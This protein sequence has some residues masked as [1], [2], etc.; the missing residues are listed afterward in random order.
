VKP[1]ASTGGDRVTRTKLTLVA[2]IAAGALACTAQAQELPTGAQAA[3]TGAAPSSAAS[4]AAAPTGAASAKADGVQSL[5][6]PS[7]SAA[8]LPPARDVR[9]PGVIVLH[10]DATDL[11][12]GVFAVHET[13]PVS[14]GGGDVVLQY[15]RWLPGNHS[16]S[17]PIDKLAGL[18]VSAGGRRIEWRRD[19]LD[20][21]AFHIA[22]PAGVTALDVDFQFL[23]PVS[24]REGRVMMTPD[25]LSLEW[26]TVALYPAGVLTRRDSAAQRAPAAR[27][28]G[29]R[30]VG[31]R[32][33]VGGTRPPTVLSTSRSWSTRR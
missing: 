7:P 30:S 32:L 27:V 3:E 10:V 24:T 26:N 21:F 22:V 19:P 33:A 15:P 13:V 18:V 12:H 5:P 9:R 29:R 8:A 20:V 28:Q 4:T 31:G 11:A 2:T 14:G 1:G 16:P 23:S 17:G 6:Q 25:M